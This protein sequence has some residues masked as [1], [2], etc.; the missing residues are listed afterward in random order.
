MNSTFKMLKANEQADLTE[1]TNTIT[2]IGFTNNALRNLDT[3]Q[4][5]QKV[6]RL[7]AHKKMGISVA[8]KVGMES[9]LVE[10]AR[11]GARY[12]SPIDYTLPG[13]TKLGNPKIYDQEVTSLALPEMLNWGQSFVERGLKHHKDIQTTIIFK[14]EE[15]H[16]SLCNT[17]GFSA[18]Y[19]S[20]YLSVL[21]GLNLTEEKNFI[22]TFDFHISTHLDLLPLE[23]I[24]KGLFTFFDLAR[25]NVKVPAGNYQVLFTPSIVANIMSPILAC[26]NGQAIVQGLSPWQ[27]KL[28]SL[29]F[30]K[31][32]TII[33]DGLLDKG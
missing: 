15:Q 29:I 1:T 6:L 31:D 30:N 26:L 7:I 9:E 2:S 17:E 12:G 27:N 10:D 21:L 22:D 32:I 19:G 5:Y 25:I 20:T 28:G 13:P 8:T 4:S 23:D 24:I 33:N 11:Q 18:S 14:R 16:F 3:K